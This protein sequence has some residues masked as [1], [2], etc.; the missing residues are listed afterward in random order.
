MPAALALSISLSEEIN[1]A[2]VGYMGFRVYFTS[3]AIRSFPVGS[4]ATIS[5]PVSENESNNST[6]QP[7]ADK[8]SRQRSSRA[9]ASL[10]LKPAFILMLNVY[11]LLIRL[12]LLINSHLVT[13]CPKQYFD[14]TVPSFPINT[15]IVPMSPRWGNSE[16]EWNDPYSLLAPLKFF[17]QLAAW[18]DLQGLLR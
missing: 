9:N 8:I 7:L 4:V 12:Y 14:N 5:I 13:S 11:P 10:V 3:K 18:G 2:E 1:R 16:S 6:C 15:P 17:M